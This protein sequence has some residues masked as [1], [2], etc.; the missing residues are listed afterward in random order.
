VSKTRSFHFLPFSHAPGTACIVPGSTQVVKIY[1]ARIDVFDY[2]DAKC[3]L[4]QT[5]ELSSVG[6]LEQFTVVQNLDKGHVQV[7][8]FSH[9]GYI[10]YRLYAANNGK[11]LGINVLKGAL[12]IE[13]NLPPLV[14]QKKE[15]LHLGCYKKQ[16]FPDVYNRQDPAEFLPLLYTL[17]QSIPEIPEAI[18][19]KPSLLT[20]LEEAIMQKQ[21]VF[22]HFRAIWRAGFT[23]LL[24]PRLV[25]TDYQG[26]FLPVIKNTNQS[27]LVLL[28]KLYPLV[29]KLF[30]EEIEGRLCFLPLLSRTLP[31]GFFSCITT[32]G[33]TVSFEWS[34]HWMHTLRIQAACDDA[35]TF[36]MP[37]ECKRYRF[38]Q[39]KKR[40]SIT[41]QNY[42][43]LELKAGQNYLLDQFQG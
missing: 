36:S 12:A 29:R 21:E 40:E 26:F 35:L 17:A 30:F 8:G 25:D 22:D 42:E 20:T 3:T 33:H 43:M 23:N 19:D 18:Q 39:N 2:G 31:F 41:C 13:Q 16:Q 37:K 28:Q 34:K 38:C 11:S 4:Q 10:A 5:I 27:P 6:P 15:R 7:S 32:K 24:L 1:P 9:A 14:V